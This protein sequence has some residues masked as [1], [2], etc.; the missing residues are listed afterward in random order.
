MKDK[1]GSGHY[2]LMCSVMD[3]IGGKKIKYDLDECE[4]TLRELSE[5]FREFSKN[6]KKFI[7]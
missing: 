6:K 2:I 1:V 4:D 3:R 5:N 7:N